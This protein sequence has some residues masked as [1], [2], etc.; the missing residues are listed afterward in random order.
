MNS[1]Q[2]TFP[3][4][5][6]STSASSGS[7]NYSNAGEF[8][9]FQDPGTP[10]SIPSHH[11][12][13]HRPPP[14]PQRPSYFPLNNRRQL[15]TSLEIKASEPDKTKEVEPKM[16]VIGE[17]ENLL[18]KGCADRNVSVLKSTAAAI[19]NRIVD[20]KRNDLALISSGKSPD[21]GSRPVDF[22]RLSFDSNN[23]VR[24]QQQHHQQPAG[25]QPKQSTNSSRLN[26]GL[27]PCRG[28]APMLEVENLNKS[29]VD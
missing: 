23:V 26:Y 8:R 28:N 29:R 27:D 18:A 20:S 4:G 14:V 19:Q 12:Y 16:A 9:T 10:P 24:C 13:H 2:Q 11:H 3:Y 1:S 5:A 22:Y 6:S 7:F 15:P 17:L 25:Y 21:R